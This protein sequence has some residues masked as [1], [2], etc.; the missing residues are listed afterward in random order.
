MDL[1]SKYSDGAGAKKKPTVD[2]SNGE[3]HIPKEGT[4][5]EI[6]AFE[7]GKDTPF[8]SNIP[9]AAICKSL[10][11]V[12]LL[13]NGGHGTHPYV[14]ANPSDGSEKTFLTVRNF[15]LPRTE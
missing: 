11:Q 10:S 15:L 6:A 2:A 5:M 3:V 7:S 4:S 13:N 1:V 14:S 8:N 9:G 12:V